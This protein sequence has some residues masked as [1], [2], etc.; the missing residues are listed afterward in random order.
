MVQNLSHRIGATVR[1]WQPEEGDAALYGLSALF[2]L[3]TIEFSGS[4]LYRQWA[5]LAV[6]PYLGAAI[7]SAVV[8]WHRRQRSA[9]EFGQR[10]P[11]APRHWSTPR[12]ALFLVVLFGATLIPL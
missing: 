11:K 1:T 6:G 8:G 9:R 12:I 2:A 5:A 3:A 10:E 4:V 7:F